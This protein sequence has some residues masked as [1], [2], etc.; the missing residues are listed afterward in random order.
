LIRYEGKRLKE[1]HRSRRFDTVAV[2]FGGIE[3]EYG[4]KKKKNEACKKQDGKNIKKF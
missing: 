1:R 2:F 4:V 3:K